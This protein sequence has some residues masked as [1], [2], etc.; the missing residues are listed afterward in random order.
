MVLKSL[1]IVFEYRSKYHLPSHWVPLYDI[2]EYIGRLT[3]DHFMMEMFFENLALY[4]RE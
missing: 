2:S 3:G 4:R 1:I